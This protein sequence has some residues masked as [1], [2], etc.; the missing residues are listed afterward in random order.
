MGGL[1]V[2]IETNPAKKTIQFKFAATCYVV[3][4]STWKGWMAQGQ[5]PHRNDLGSG[6]SP[7][8][9]SL[10]CRSGV[11]SIDAPK[12]KVHC[13]SS[14][15]E[16]HA[17]VPGAT[18]RKCADAPLCLVYKSCYLLP[19]TIEKIL[20]ILLGVSTPPVESKHLLLVLDGVTSAIYNLKYITWGVRTTNA[21]KQLLYV[22]GMVM[23]KE[24]AKLQRALIQDRVAESP[25]LHNFGQI[26]SSLSIWADLNGVEEIRQAPVDMEK[27]IYLN[28]LARFL[29]YHGYHVN[30]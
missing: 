14:R 16:R 26:N 2:N 24:K 10:R 30:D 11:A 7:S 28:W 6:V 8:I 25:N 23:K 17:F 3:G 22:H 4:V 18:S 27:L 12:P 5:L 1:V 20:D 13:W 21:L 15:W 19:V 9:L 29:N